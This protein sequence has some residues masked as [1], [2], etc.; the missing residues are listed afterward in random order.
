MLNLTIQHMIHLTRD[1]RYAVHEGIELVVPG[2]SIP[3]WFMEKATSEPAK[4]VFCHYYF[5]NPKEDI[6]VQIKEDGF[7]ICLPFRPGKELGLTDEQWRE[8]NLRNPE[9]LE[10][11]YKNTPS[12]VSS[13]NLLDLKDGGSGHLMY[14][15][16][17]KLKQ[18]NKLLNVMHFIQIGDMQALLDSL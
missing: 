12:E 10:L 3:I 2:V 4:E 6:P 18:N 1:Q 13:K 8:L 15:E 9:K 11:M 7:E 5:K 14:R 17:N 16:H